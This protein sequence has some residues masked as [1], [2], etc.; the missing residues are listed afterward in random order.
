MR[1]AATAMLKLCWKLARHELSPTCEIHSQNLK[2]CGQSTM[3]TE[4]EHIESHDIPWTCSSPS[5]VL[6]VVCR[7]LPLR[8][9]LGTDRQRTCSSKCLQ[10]G[11]SDASYARWYV[12]ICLV[13]WDSPLPCILADEWRLSVVRG[14]GVLKNRLFLV[15]A[16]V[17]TAAGQT[18]RDSES[19]KNLYPKNLDTLPYITQTRQ[20]LYI[21]L[22]ET[23]RIRTKVLFVC[24]LWAFNSKEIWWANR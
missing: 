13:C 3:E 8:S 22:L 20:C 10:V 24:S 11:H 19:Q 14:G 23:W 4:R 7:G 21:N 16:L 2:A 5:M 15:C 9:S 6:P 12:W 17:E 18:V 1:I